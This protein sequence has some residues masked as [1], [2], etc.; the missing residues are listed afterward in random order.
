MSET[1]FDIGQMLCSAFYKHR[2]NKNS[3]FLTEIK[4]VT[5]QK[6][7]RAR[8]FSRFICDALNLENDPAQH[9]STSNLFG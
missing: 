5:F 3:D 9:E 7:V 2:T 4:P 6:L 8:S 1:M